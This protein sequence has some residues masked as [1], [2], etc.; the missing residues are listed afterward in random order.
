MEGDHMRGNRRGRTTYLAIAG[1]VLAV[2]ASVAVGDPAVAA[3]P[4]RTSTGLAKRG[5]ISLP[6]NAVPGSTPQRRAAWERLTPQGKQEAAAR[7]QTLVGSRMRIDRD[8]VSPRAAAPTVAQALSGTAN[9][10]VRSGVAMPTFTAEKL[11]VP[12]SQSTGT[13]FSDPDSDGLDQAFEAATAD[14]FTP[15]Y[16]VS[17]GEQPG[18]GLATFYNSVPQTVAQVFGP[19]PP[20]SYF[21]VQPLG[22]G[23]DSAGALV[24]VLRIDYLTLWNRDDGFE[25][26][27][28]CGAAIGLVESLTGIDFV[29]GG[30]QLDN[31]RS[32]ALVAAPVSPSGGYNENPG[33]YRLYSYYTAAHEGTFGGD[34]SAYYFFNPP[35]PANNHIQLGLSRSKHGTYTFNPDWYPVI[36]PEIMSLTYFTIDSLY[37]SY[38]IDYE[39]Y[40][41]FLYLA[42]EAFFAC[43]V[44]HF[45]E[46]GGTYAQ[47]RID[48]GEPDHVI[49]GAGFIQDTQSG[50]REKFTVPLW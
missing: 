47:T 28:V 39:T 24:G 27:G 5:E 48:V 49:N 19:V 15:Y 34:N 38:A 45:S 43:F 25:T 35:V 26:F 7:L 11:Q 12:V 3:Y 36:W 33:S 30:H 20:I 14:M 29:T 22:F 41:I 42:D 32:A 17:S 50:I 4:G 21:R 6:H 40:L 37:F 31:E 2:L 10:A 46:Q 18:T 16:H 13:Q 8:A 44:E 9:A 1:L 23:T